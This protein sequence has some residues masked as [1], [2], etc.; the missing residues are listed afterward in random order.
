MREKVADPLADLFPSGAV[1]SAPLFFQ[2]EPLAE[3]WDDA[4]ALAKV[5]HAEVG[6]L[7]EKDFA[8]ERERYLRVAESGSLK[9]YTARAEGRLVGYAIFFLTE[10]LHYQGVKWALQDVLFLHPEFRG[11]GGARFMLWTDFALKHAGADV[12]H[13]HVSEKHDYSRSLERMGYTLVDRGYIRRIG[14]A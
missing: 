2:E 11:I 7:P 6:A 5:H 12:I 1:E 3:I 9:V 10:H 8:P 4:Q 13:R 14:D